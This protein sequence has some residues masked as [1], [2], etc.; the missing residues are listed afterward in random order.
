MIRIILLLSCITQLAAAVESKPPKDVDPSYLLR[1]ESGRSCNHGSAIAVTE[2]RLVTCWHLLDRPEKNK[3]REIFVKI[4]KD[5]IHC[6]IIGFNKRLDVAIL[7]CDTKLGSFLDLSKVSQNAAKCKCYGSK[8]DEKIVPCDC[9]LDDDGKLKA[10]K[11]KSLGEGSS[12]NALVSERVIG[13]VTGIFKD[14]TVAW[15]GCEEIGGVLSQSKG[16][17]ETTEEGRR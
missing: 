13:M 7:Y 14:G 5:W 16:K 11:S 8:E 1:M 3:D 15:V 9:E 4:N 17:D 2:H 6:E 12:G 10:S